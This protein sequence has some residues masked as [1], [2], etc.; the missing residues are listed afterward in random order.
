MVFAKHLRVAGD[1]FR[2]K[3]LQSTDEADRTH[4]NEDWTQM[5][6]KL[7]V[8]HNRWDKLLFFAVHC[9]EYWKRCMNLTLPLQTA[10]IELL[11]KLVPEMVRFEPTWEE[12]ELYKDGGM[13]VIDQWICA[14]AR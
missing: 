10:K 12:L 8:S 11:K 4:Y 1:E 5:K 3:Y 13:A 14:H 7:T 9:R 6:V 2:N